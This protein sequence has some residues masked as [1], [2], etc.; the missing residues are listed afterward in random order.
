MQRYTKKE[1]DGS[2]CLDVDAFL[3][4][5]DADAVTKKAVQRLAGF[6]NVYESL[7][8]SI[9]ETA[10]KLDELRDRGKVDTATFKQLLGKKIQYEN[11]LSLF[12]I[13]GVE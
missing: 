3:L 7:Q 10:L 2:Y 9:T 13:Y 11:T 6:E 4:E 12:K 5:Q 1:E 8:Q